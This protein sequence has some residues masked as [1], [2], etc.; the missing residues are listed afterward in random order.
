M[1]KIFLSLIMLTS[2][3]FA[4]FI[5]GNELYD[6]YQKG[7]NNILS[8][9]GFYDGYVLGIFDAYY[10]ILFCPPINIKSGQVLDIVLKYLQNHPEIRNKPADYIVIKAL[11]E[12]WP[13]K[14]KKGSK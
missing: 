13:C 8:A 2:L 4:G 3:S 9:G 12:V 7:Q 1:Q 10:N 6:K 11:Q 14:L 5:D